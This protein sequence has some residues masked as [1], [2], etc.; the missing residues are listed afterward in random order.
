MIRKHTTYDP[1]QQLLITELRGEIGH[2]DLNDWQ[3]QLQTVLDVIPPAAKFKVLVNLYGFKAADLAT[4]K[5]FREIIPRT[6]AGFGWY[7][8]YLRMFPE[9]DV[10]I[11]STN[12]RYCIAAAHVHDDEEKIKNYA[13]NFTMK[14]EGFFSDPD[15]A[16]AW[17][18]SIPVTGN[19]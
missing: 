19:P 6:L 7:T 11:H 13:G 5:Q 1:Q 8:G 10:R 3:T 16:R 9:A 17:I 2:A 4:H 14:N 15:M 12:G 18:D